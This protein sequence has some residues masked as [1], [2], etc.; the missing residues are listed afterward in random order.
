MLLSGST[1]GLALL[2]LAFASVL[3]SF[4]K[5]NEEES[6]KL[7]T[8]NDE[9]DEDLKCAIVKR[10]SFTGEKLSEEKIQ[11]ELVRIKGF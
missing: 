6:N 2:G 4:K 8:W 5:S 7:K 3:D 1:A 9:I 10:A 11:L